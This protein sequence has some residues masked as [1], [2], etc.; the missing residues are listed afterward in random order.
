MIQGPT[1]LPNGELAIP[2]KKSRGKLLSLDEILILRN[3]ADS[4]TSSESREFLYSLIEKEFITD[5]EKDIMNRILCQAARQLSSN[6]AIE[7]LPE[8]LSN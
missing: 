3:T 4:L 2:S 6:D 1:V 5:N 8:M 7:P